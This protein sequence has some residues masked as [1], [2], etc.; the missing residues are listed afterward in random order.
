M[1]NL[2]IHPK[3]LDGATLE[4]TLQDAIYMAKIL[5]CMVCFYF[6]DTLY[7][8]MPDDGPDDWED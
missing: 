6:N 5:N 2:K 8:I 7:E 1:V 3:V 4:D